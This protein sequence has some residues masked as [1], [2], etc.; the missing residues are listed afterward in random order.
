MP[1]IRSGN[2]PSFISITM[3]RIMYPVRLKLCCKYALSSDLIS[4]E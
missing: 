3:P 2:C 4:I 1:A